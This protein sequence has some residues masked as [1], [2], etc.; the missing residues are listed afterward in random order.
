MK[1]DNFEKILGAID[2]KTVERV[3]INRY[4]KTSQSKAERA[5]IQKT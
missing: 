5:E 2:E 1:T 4:K 3:L